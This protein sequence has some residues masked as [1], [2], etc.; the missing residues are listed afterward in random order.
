MGCFHCLY[1]TRRLTLFKI[2]LLG[3]SN[4]KRGFRTFEKPTIDTN[5]NRP[6][7]IWIWAFSPERHHIN[8]HWNIHTAYLRNR[9]IVIHKYFAVCFTRIYYINPELRVEYYSITNITLLLYHTYYNVDESQSH[10]TIPK[11]PD[12]EGQIMWDSFTQHTKAGKLTGESKLKVASVWRKRRL[13]NGHRISS[14]GNK[15]VRKLDHSDRC[16]MM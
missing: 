13:L 10:Y 14:G 1:I 6:I 7:P 11:K 2:S 12:T 5:K 4:K 15:I 16:T 9:Y 3:N 8:K